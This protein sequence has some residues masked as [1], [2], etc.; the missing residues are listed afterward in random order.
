MLPKP[1]II[2]VFCFFN[3]LFILS[4]AVVQRCSVKNVFLEISQNSQSLFFKVAVLR[5]AT[6]LKKRLWHRCFPMSFVKFLRTLFFTE[7]LRWLLLYFQ[8]LSNILW[9]G[10]AFYGSFNMTLKSKQTFNFIINVI[11]SHK[12][13]ILKFSWLT[14][15]TKLLIR[16]VICISNLKEIG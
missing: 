14:M 2:Q 4:E 13:I 1:F 15:L 11:F 10:R 12:V 5:S 6:L 3:L 16:P 9:Q 8:S 7:H